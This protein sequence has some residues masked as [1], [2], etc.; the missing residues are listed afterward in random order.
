MEVDFH[1]YCLAV[2]ARTVGFT[3]KE[4]LTIAYAS[5]YVDDSTESEPIMVGDILFDSVRTAHYGLDAFIPITI[6]NAR[7]VGV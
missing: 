1:Y 4:A 2:L 5:Q 6:E 3:K 7:F